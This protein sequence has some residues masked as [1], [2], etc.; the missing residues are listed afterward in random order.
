MPMRAPAAAWLLCLGLSMGL[1]ADPAAAFLNDE[2]AR[3]AI[4]ELRARI[5]T[6]EEAATKREAENSAAATA[7]RTRL[8]EEIATL[9]RSLL[10]LNNQI[11][12]LRSELAKLSG[13]DET[14]ARDLAEAQRRQRD[15]TAAFDE[16]LKKIE[17]VK[18]VLDGR[19]F[20]VEQEEKRSYDEAFAAIRSGDFDKSSQLF[21]TFLRRFPGSPYADAA[22]FWLGN[23]QYGRR[24]YKGA[25]DSFRGFVTASPLHPR[26]PDALLALANS[27]AEMKDGRAARR[28]IEELIKEY[29]S[30]EAAQAGRDRLASLPR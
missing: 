30:S 3:K 26:A 18:V 8:Q 25:I 21:S 28:T 13:T 7:E 6:I 11:S 1:A 15:V 10:E 5:A 4:V 23:S 29:P 2:E 9:R 14:L 16:R 24:D 20:M 22:R 17:P 12:T 19:E 27:Q